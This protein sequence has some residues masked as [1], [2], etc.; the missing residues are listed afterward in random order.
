MIDNYWIH[1]VCSSISPLAYYMHFLNWHAW[2]LCRLDWHRH[3]LN[4]WHERNIWNTLFHDD[5]QLFDSRGLL[6]C[7]AS[8]FF[9]WIDTH[10]PCSGWFGI[11]QFSFQLYTERE[12]NPVRVSS[13]PRYEMLILWFSNV[14][15]PYSI[16][17]FQVISLAI[18]LN[19]VV[20]SYS[21]HCFLY[22][23]PFSAIRSDKLRI[24]Q[25]YRSQLL[26]VINDCL[27]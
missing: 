10:G 23:L 22:Y 17:F 24:H 15:C 18:A 4:F 13:T 12:Y 3:E 5:R 25:F 1:E 14:Q 8:C 7:F 27:W 16:S 9:S 21:E 26:S 11:E 6:F 19:V 20:Y 2:S